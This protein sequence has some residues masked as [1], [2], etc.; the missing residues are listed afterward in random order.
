M[1]EKVV[2]VIDDDE[3][4]D[5]EVI[6]ID[7]EESTSASIFGTNYP[8]SRKRHCV[9]SSDEDCVQIAAEP[10]RGWLASSK[11]SPSLK[12]DTG[13]LCLSG[14]K[15]PGCI[16]CS[17]SNTSNK[18]NGS[19]TFN[20]NCLVALQ[21]NGGIT[22][23]QSSIIKSINVH[24]TTS[25]RCRTPVSTYTPVSSVTCNPH[26]A[27]YTPKTS[28][29]KC[30]ISPTALDINNVSAPL[31]T[32]KQLASSKKS[33]SKRRQKPK[34]KTVTKTDTK[35]GDETDYKSSLSIPMFCIRSTGDISTLPPVMQFIVSS[36]VPF[37]SCE[38]PSWWSESKFFEV[39]LE[40]PEARTIVYPLE[41]SG[42]QVSK[43]ERIQTLH[44]WIR[45]LSE[46]K[47]LVHLRAENFKL[48]EALL[49]HC[50]RGSK[51]AI[52]QEGLDV[53][54]TH[55]GNFG[56]GIYFRYLK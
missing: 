16:Q 18:R 35:S 55:G 27:S 14:I 21:L 49:Y 50:S 24:A 52:C 31:S 25:S 47:L 10:K 22:A 37:I 9:S 6:I 46:V 12:L 45:Y 4:E 42:F 34:T 7:G 29:T 38:A 1:A 51:N 17:T 19:S 23:Q 8:T 40:D 13:G 30:S 53:R 48:N 3:P 41:Y 36:S 20:K 44:L 33:R 32:V 2:I 28:Q 11:E 43:V 56:R 26:S 5:N 39:S 15:S 54:L